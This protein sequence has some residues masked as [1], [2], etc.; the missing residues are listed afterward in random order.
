[1]GHALQLT[2]T[3][4]KCAIKPRWQVVVVEVDFETTIVL[5]SVKILKRKKDCTVGIGINK[6]V[7][8]QQSLTSAQRA[9]QQDT[10][11]D[12]GTPPRGSAAILAEFHQ[13]K[14]TT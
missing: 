9:R 10:L 6:L 13:V 7:R 1:M 3:T 14:K 8:S 5:R 2:E 12:P 11:R 4:S